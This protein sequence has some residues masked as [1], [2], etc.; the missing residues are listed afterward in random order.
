V[1]TVDA[2]AEIDPD[3]V[4]PM[5]CSGETFIAEAMRRMPQKVVRPYVGSRFIFGQVS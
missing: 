5:H 3:Y 4:I 1:R 2:L